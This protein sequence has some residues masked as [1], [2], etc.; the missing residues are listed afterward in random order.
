MLSS[1]FICL[2]FDS[3]LPAAVRR[4]CCGGCGRCSLRLHRPQ[5]PRWRQSPAALLLAARNPCNGSR[6]P[7]TLWSQFET[8]EADLDNVADAGLVGVAGGLVV[9]VGAVGAAGVLH[10]PGVVAIPQAR[11]LARDERFGQ[12]DV[13]GGAASDGILRR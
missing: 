5:P 11:M 13:A 2:V 9:Q 1:I 7:A 12:E 8:D 3:S 4:F 10:V 6:T